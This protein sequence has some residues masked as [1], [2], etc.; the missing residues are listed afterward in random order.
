LKEELAPIKEQNKAVTM[1]PRRDSSLPTKM[2]RTNLLAADM[3]IPQQSFPVVSLISGAK[4]GEAKTPKTNSL[5]NYGFV[6][7][8]AFLLPQKSTSVDSTRLVQDR[9]A[10]TALLMIPLCMGVETPMKKL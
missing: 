3:K 5:P 2:G 10:L 7:P 4:R 8:L 6:C 9:T 1:E